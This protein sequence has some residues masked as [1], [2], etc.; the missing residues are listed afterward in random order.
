MGVSWMMEV[1]SFAVG[2]SAYIWI[3]TDILNILTGVFIFI[4]FVCKPNVWK[5][6]KV[7]CPCLEQLDSCCPSFML[8][9]NTRQGTTTRSTRNDLSVNKSLSAPG[10]VGP[11]NRNDSKKNNRISSTVTLTQ[12]TQLRDSTHVDSEDEIILDQE[13]NN[14]RND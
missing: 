4:I 1:I 6:L 11:N 13:S 2:G 8:R 7:K 5:L 12:S 3:P 9:S 10:I 14:I